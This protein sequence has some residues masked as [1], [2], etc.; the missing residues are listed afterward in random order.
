MLEREFPDSLGKVLDIGCGPGDVPVRLAKAFPDIRITAIDGSGPMIRLAREAVRSAGVEERVNPVRGYIPG[1]ALEERGFDAVLCKDMIHHLPDPSVLWEEAKRL[2]RP[3]AAI[4]VMDLYRPESAETARQIVE[5]VSPDED[6]I[7]KLDF[8]NSLC[9]A[10]T[11]EEIEE[12]LKNAGL[13]LQVEKVSE[14]HVVIKG[15]LPL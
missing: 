8:F 11:V 6:P 2:G 3:G 9:A 15:Y 5:S 10:F 7:L 12:Q 14:R 4:C 1:L 13:S